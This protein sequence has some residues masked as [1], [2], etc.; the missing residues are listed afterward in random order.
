VP[1]RDVRGRNSSLRGGRSSGT[2]F[3]SGYQL[4]QYH[5]QRLTS[6]GAGGGIDTL[7]AEAVRLV[8]R[9]WELNVDAGGTPATHSTEAVAAET[10]VGAILLVTEYRLKSF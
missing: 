9:I 4:V 5:S 6:V 8:D 10:A 2:R 7:S 3:P 1:T